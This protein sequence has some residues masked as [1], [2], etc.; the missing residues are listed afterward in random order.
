M[1]VKYATGKWAFGF[2]DTCSFRYPLADLKSLIV[3]GHPINVR[4]CPECFDQDHPQLF[5]GTVHINDPQ[6]IKDPRPDTGLDES[7]ILWGWNPV[8]NNAVFMTAQIGNIFVET[9]NG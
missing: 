9:S 8:G 6:A 3:K 7:R 5:L 4:V 1:A 2:C